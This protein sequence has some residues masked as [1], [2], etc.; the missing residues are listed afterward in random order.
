MIMKDKIIENTRKLLTNNWFVLSM[1]CLLLFFERF[2]VYCLKNNCIYNVCFGW[3]IVVSLFIILAVIFIGRSVGAYKF[4]MQIVKRFLSNAIGLKWL[5]LVFILGFLVHIEWI[6]A[7]SYNLFFDGSGHW[8]EPI[9]LILGLLLL[10][11]LFPVKSGKERIDNKAKQTLLVTGLTVPPRSTVLISKD[12]LDLLFKPLLIYK[13]IEQIAILP[14]PEL[15]EKIKNTKSSEEDIINIKND[16]RSALK[17]CEQDE[18]S[19]KNLFD[20]YMECIK[21]ESR[22]QINR[23]ITRF[24]DFYIKNAKNESMLKYSDYANKSIKIHFSP[25]SE[26]YDNFEKCYEGFGELIK[27]YEGGNKNATMKTLIHITPGTK[28]VTASL[29]LHAIKGYRKMIYTRQSDAKLDKVSMDVWTLE[30]LLNELWKELDE[31]N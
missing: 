28:I 15:Y 19:I 5:S 24:F 16:L 14:S 30:E 31:I 8:F 6:A 17:E 2:T 13:D 18:V 26:D 27:K 9:I 7:A 25:E 20:S 21:S 12:S 11:A 29:T 10:C 22:S 4:R 1:F 23:M 3:P